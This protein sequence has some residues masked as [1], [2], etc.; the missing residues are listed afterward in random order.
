MTAQEV[1]QVEIDHQRCNP[2]QIPQD[3]QFLN[4]IGNYV[5]AYRADTAKLKVGWSLDLFF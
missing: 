5:Y 2:D 4:F 3:E 1:A